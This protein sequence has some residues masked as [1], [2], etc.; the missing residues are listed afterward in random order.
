MTPNPRKRA[1][2]KPTTCC[3]VVLLLPAC[4][5]IPDAYTPPPKPKPCEVVVMDGN[6]KSGECIS[7]EAFQRWRKANG[8]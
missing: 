2:P 7:R 3:L 6:T 1:A 8:L 5:G 4:A